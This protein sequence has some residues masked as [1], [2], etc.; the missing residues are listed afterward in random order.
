MATRGMESV[1]FSDRGVVRVSVPVG[2]LF[3]YKQMQEVTR[4]VI[5]RLGCDECHSGWD[6][7]FD[8][9]RQF[10]FDEK[11]KLMGGGVIIDG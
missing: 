8:A 4:I 7:R 11:L 1:S 3:N 9:I 10:V 5:G 6:I 2:V